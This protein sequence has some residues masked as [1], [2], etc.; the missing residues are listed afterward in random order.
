MVSSVG[1]EGRKKTV[2]GEHAITATDVVLGKGKKIAR[3]PGNVKFRTIIGQ[4]R[5]AYKN[6]RKRQQE[7]IAIAW[8]VMSLV[9]SQT[10]PGRFLERDC[11][12]GKGKLVFKEICTKR[13]LEKIRQ[14]LREKRFYLPGA[15]PPKSAA[16]KSTTPKHVMTFSPMQE[17]PRPVNEQS[18]RL[19][20]PSR[21]LF[22]IEGKALDTSTPTAECSSPFY[23]SAQDMPV[24]GSHPLAFVPSNAPSRMIVMGPTK[25]E[26]SGVPQEFESN[27]SATTQEKELPLH[28]EVFIGYIRC[29]PTSLKEGMDPFDL[30]ALSVFE[31]PD[32]HSELSY[33]VY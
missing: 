3:L 16:S 28:L 6:L 7:K 24:Y 9:E 26:Q 23:Y 12:V 13:A 30:D 5:S 32:D 29:S 11:S 20:L 22:K 14:T 15:P 27:G 25:I 31:V 8:K 19:V 33:L 17:K 4:F 10:P 21:G 1:R 18:S 2:I